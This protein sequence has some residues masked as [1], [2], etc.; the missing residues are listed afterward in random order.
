MC[1]YHSFGCTSLIII[2]A[3]R[4]DLFDLLSILYPEYD[5]CSRESNFGNWVSHFHFAEEK[6]KNVN[7]YML[8]GVGLGS[9]SCRVA[10]SEPIPTID[11]I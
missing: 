1:Y 11:W 4:L 2:E 7:K 5:Y 10:I 9:F 6:C 3:S 8:Y